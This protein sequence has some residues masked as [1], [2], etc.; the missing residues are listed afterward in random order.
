MTASLLFTLLG[1]ALSA[2][3]TTTLI[4]GPE[5]RSARILGILLIGVAMCACIEAGRHLP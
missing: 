5:T 1:L 2:I 4:E 3:G